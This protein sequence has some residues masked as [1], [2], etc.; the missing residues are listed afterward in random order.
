MRSEEATI[1]VEIQLIE[2][3]AQWLENFRDLRARPKVQARSERLIDGNSGVA[4][5]VG[6]DVSELGI[7]FDH[8][9]GQRR[10]VNT[11]T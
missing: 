1:V 3:F 6:S 4:K 2:R 10:K 5:P 8:P 9:L 11:S 7:N